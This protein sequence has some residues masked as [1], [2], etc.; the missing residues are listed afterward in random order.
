MPPYK[1]EIIAA[2]V[3]QLKPFD[4][5]RQLD[6]I[7]SDME[8]LSAKTADMAK[9]S[10]LNNFELESRKALEESF[11]RNS[12]NPAQLQAE[13]QKIQQK[14][15]SALPSKEMREEAKLRFAVHAMGYMGKAKQNQYNQ[16]LKALQASALDK[17]NVITNNIRSLGKGLYD[18]NLSVS[19]TAANTIGLEI[20]SLESMTAERD[21][22]GNFVL[23]PEKQAILKDNVRTQLTLADMDFFNG[24]GTTKEKENFYK[25]YK[26]KKTKKIWLD[27]EDERGYSEQAMTENNTDWPTYEKNLA[28]MEHQLNTLKQERL[29][30]L[31][32]EVQNKFASAEYATKMRIE[33]MNETL[34][35]KQ[36]QGDPIGIYE[37]LSP[38][39]YILDNATQPAYTDPEGRGLY[40]IDM[41]KEALPLSKQFV[42]YARQAVDD[43]MSNKSKEKS[44][45]GSGLQVLRQVIK[46]DPSLNDYDQLDL[47]TYF[48]RETR[49]N[50]AFKGINLM[51]PAD[52]ATR[53]DIMKAAQKAIVTLYANKG[54]HLD[55]EQISNMTQQHPVR[56][57][58][59]PRMFASPYYVMGGAPM[60]TGINTQV[61]IPSWRDVPVLE[62][63]GKFFIKRLKEAG[64]A[65]GADKAGGA[66]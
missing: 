37:A 60:D 27:P 57:V 55:E 4:Y 41:N 44:R 45:F 33:W 21:A 30:G 36:A 61:T 17:A 59:D 15:I 63:G 34:K 23:S 66:L 5:T 47:V 39:A 48:Y 50:P 11:E 1:K 16:E 8:K 38:L 56:I 43:F 51:E 7:A 65:Y 32:Q 10:F 40:L 14:F 25:A 58:N 29:K 6:S 2:D 62:K 26:A 18:T 52:A 28:A 22:Q 20:A 3:P 53:P 42:P 12:N 13:Q 49:D 19:G 35:N 46:N 54:L 24:L 9:T 64:E 31:Q